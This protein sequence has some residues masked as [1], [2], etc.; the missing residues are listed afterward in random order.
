MVLDIFQFSM[1]WVV[2]RAL[3]NIGWSNGIKQAKN[4]LS[5]HKLLT[6]LRSRLVSLQLAN[7]EVLHEVYQL[8]SPGVGLEDQDQ[9]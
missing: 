6:Y 8:A 7:I 9:A 3:Q 1:L 4:G 5:E 2:Y